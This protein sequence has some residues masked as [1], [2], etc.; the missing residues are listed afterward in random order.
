M[1][2][3]LILNIKITEHGSH[4]KAK[5]TPEQAMKAQRWSRGFALLF[6]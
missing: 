6:L 3:I 5:V 2:S 4:N 1:D